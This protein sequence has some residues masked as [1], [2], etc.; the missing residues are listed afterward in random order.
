MRPLL[1]VFLL[2]EAL[3]LALYLQAPHLE[4]G[5]MAAVPPAAVVVAKVCAVALVIGLA[6][7]LARIWPRWW[8]AGLVLAVGIAVGA[9][10]AGTAAATLSIVGALG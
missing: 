1:V 10:G 4:S 7:L 5:P 2:V 8:G 3:D 9:F 6:S